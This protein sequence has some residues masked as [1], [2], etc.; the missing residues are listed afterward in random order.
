MN[1]N[2][3]K[4]LVITTF[5]G[6]GIATAYAAD[7]DPKAISALL[8]QSNVS[9]LEGIDVAEKTS[10][11][12]TSAKFEVD[13]GKLVLSVYTVPEGLGVEPEKATLTEVGGDAMESPFKPKV[14]VF[15]DKEHIARASVH[16][17]LFQVSHLTLKQVIQQALKQKA[18]VPIDVRNPMIRNHRPIAD[19]VIVASNQEAFTVTVDL[20]NGKASLKTATT[21]A[22]P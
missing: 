12:A 14:E 3:E 18:G 20:L 19:V 4:L 8:K 7:H 1:R 22:K 17:T 10:G 13:A 15:S 16:M 9:L 6:L 21:T 11:V 5:M 2:L